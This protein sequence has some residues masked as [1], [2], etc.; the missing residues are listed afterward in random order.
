MGNGSICICTSSFG[1]NTEFLQYQ[2]LTLGPGCSFGTLTFE[3]RA[4]DSGGGCRP[5]SDCLFCALSSN[6]RTFVQWSGSV[7][8]RCP[9]SRWSLPKWSQRTSSLLWNWWNPL[10]YLCQC[11]VPANAVL[12]TFIALVIN[13]SAW[14]RVYI[15]ARHSDHFHAWLQP[16]LCECALCGLPPGSPSTDLLFQAPKPLWVLSA[17]TGIC[18]V[19]LGDEPPFFHNQLYSA[20]LMGQGVFEGQRPRTAHLQ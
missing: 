7:S 3:H 11:F 8:R 4:W 10:R 15:L 12:S 6:P 16:G 2:P 5:V 18:F 9:C 1:F 17:H 20:R 13:P 14:D 19:S